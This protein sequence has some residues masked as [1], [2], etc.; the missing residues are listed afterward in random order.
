MPAEAEGS[1]SAEAAAPKGPGSLADLEEVECRYLADMDRL[2]NAEEGEV[3]IDELDGIGEPTGVIAAVTFVL[4][5]SV[6]ESR[7]RC[8]V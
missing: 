3:D 6:T 4:S 2:G 8:V 5:G 7:N 1:S